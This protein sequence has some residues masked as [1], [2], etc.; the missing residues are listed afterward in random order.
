MHRSFTSCMRR[1]YA[2]ESG[3][4]AI[5]FAISSTLVLLAAGMA[6]DV[7]RTV[8]MNSRIGQAADAA[9]LAAG[10]AMLDGK[11]NDTEVVAL[12]KRYLKHNA[13][14]GG[15][16]PGRYSEPNISINRELGSVHVDVDV[17]VPTTLSRISGRQELRAPV[18]N[19][20][21]FEQKDVEVAMA[22]D[23][24]GSMT[25][26]AG[27]GQRKIDAL[28][29]SFGTFV[30]KLRFP[31][32][33][34]TGARCASPSPPIRPASTC[35][36]A[37]CEVRALEIGPKHVGRELAAQALRFHQVLSRV[38]GRL[39]PVRMWCTTGAKRIDELMSNAPI[40]IKL[41]AA[42]LA[43]SALGLVISGSPDFADASPV[44]K[45][46]KLAQAAQDE[47]AAEDA[48][49]EDEKGDRKRRGDD[50]GAGREQQKQQKEA[51]RAE[52]KQEKEAERAAR[53]QQKEADRDAREQQKQEEADGAARKQQEDAER[54]ERKQ[55]QEAERAAREQQKEAERAAREQQKDAE[56]AAKQQQQKEAERASGKQQEEAERAAQQKQ[57]A[58]RAPKGQKKDAE[59]A[60]K[61]KQQEE[62]E[63]SAREQQEQSE[64]AKAEAEKQRVD[65]DAA[66]PTEQ[67]QRTQTETETDRSRVEPKD[68]E[69]VREAPRGRERRFEPKTEK[70]AVDQLKEERAGADAEFEKAKRE[71]AQERIEV[72]KRAE[73]RDTRE[74]TQAF[75]QVRRQRRERT[76]DGGRRAILEE[77]D[78]RRIILEKDRAYVRHDEER[79]F[80]RLGKRVKRERRKD[81]TTL[82]IYL[83]IGGVEIINIE[84]E[85]GRLLRRSRRGAGGREIVLVDNSRFYKSRPRGYGN[86]FLRLPPPSVR[87][88]RAKYIVD[89]DEASED[90]IYEALIAPPVERLDRRYS[91]EEVRYG[92]G[93]RERM[94]RV[95]LDA[96]N[97]AFGSW[98]VEESQ[99][100]RLERI[101]RVLKR[102]LQRNPD[103]M[104]MIE[105][106]TDA[107]GSDIDNLSLS[108]RRAE[109]V[110]IILSDEFRVPPENLTTQGYGE[111]YLKVPS[112]GPSRENRRVAVRRITPLLSQTD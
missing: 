18:D 68:D 46:V 55:Q 9:S 26:S 11:L 87:I 37:L 103:E 41:L 58:E 85:D 45:I 4:I 27:G 28:K 73:G 47:P 6:I 98:E 93:V 109:S 105:G 30:D 78:D 12:A 83:S 69:V 3:N 5:V 29:K 57:E 95:D 34:P 90:D 60:G 110:A 51:E 96:I 94:R 36:F 65:T 64:R 61:Q 66:K 10:R 49:S 71:A 92:Y 17:R 104:F 89:Y 31:N 100:P 39:A 21:V 44:E 74:K 13:E 50:N 1:L 7:G 35:R 42:A 112:E 111:E 23:V 19:T 16:L 80:A 38:Q 24:T 91:L 99:Y 20:T 43:G 76:E 22:L 56:R 25:E 75:E 88:S 84:D 62:A 59:R 102:V 8:S 2:D 32:T 15:K 101:A 48:P 72:G 107:V 81:G 67:K 33:C 106:H 52:R 77:P 97:F 53:E 79:R 40:T 63:R 14:S 86:V 108:D 70:Q 54:G 82:S